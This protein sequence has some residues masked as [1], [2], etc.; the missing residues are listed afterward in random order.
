MYIYTQTTHTRIQTE[1][2]PILKLE[3]PLHQKLKQQLHTNAC[4]TSEASIS[5]QILDLDP[6]NFDAYRVQQSFDKVLE[7]SIYG[8]GDNYILDANDMFH[9]VIL[10]HHDGKSSSPAAISQPEYV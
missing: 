2:S 5:T 9:I 8:Y 3:W 6:T 10:L 1:K 4:T 7:T